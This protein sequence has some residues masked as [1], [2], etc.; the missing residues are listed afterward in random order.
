VA[1]RSGLGRGL[2]AL[3]PSENP[4]L[5][6]SSALRDV[7][8]SQIRPNQH[9]PR[10]RFDEEAMSSL[11]G[12]IRE[13]GVL[14]PVLL[15][16]TGEEEYELIAGERR[17]R[18]ARRAGLQ[19]VPALVQ[20]TSDVSSLEQALVENLHREDLNP[21]EEAAAYLQLIEDFGLTHEVL[22]QRVGRSRAAV[23]NSLRLF[24]LP[25]AVQR[26]LSDGMINAGQA[27]ALLG[28]PDREAQERLA[29]E[30]VELGL[31]VRAVE[32]AVRA[33]V[34]LESDELS[35]DGSSDGEDP[36]P[37]P[38]QANG[39]TRHRPRPLRPPGALELEELLANHLSTRVRV[40]MRAKR[41]RVIID[42][43]TLEDLE[44]IYQIMINESSASG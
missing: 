2:S 29:N 41:G 23:T 33:L 8:L 31:S 15:R 17:W 38:A 21:L 11:A 36:V 4:A 14:Q 16:E 19:S 13:L 12:S 40:E 35:G 7:P 28:T 24:Q 39:S 32:D 27:R 3:I 43:A 20:S 37:T 42:F 25:P 30:I 22:A 5:A 34:A 9:Q 10:R 26:L 1:R 44:R 18:A 6:H